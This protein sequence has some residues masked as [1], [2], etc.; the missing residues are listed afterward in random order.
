MNFYELQISRKCKIL[1]TLQNILSSAFLHLDILYDF[2]AF[3]EETLHVH[4]IIIDSKFYGHYNQSRR[5]KSS[6]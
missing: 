2:I 4:L 6:K 3:I 1:L 5:E